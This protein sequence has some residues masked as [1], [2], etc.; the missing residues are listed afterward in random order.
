MINWKLNH[1]LCCLSI[2]ILKTIKTRMFERFPKYSYEFLYQTLSSK[3]SRND[4]HYFKASKK[5]LSV[6][7]ASLNFIIFL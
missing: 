4:I 1:D 6:Y 2:F 3:K 7:L 5:I